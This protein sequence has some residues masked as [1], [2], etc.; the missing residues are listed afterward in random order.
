MG[1]LEPAFASWLPYP[2]S[3]CTIFP[4]KHFC[5]SRS[6]PVV[7]SVPVVRWP[8]ED[9]VSSSARGT[10]RMCSVLSTYDLPRIR[11]PRDVQESIF[12]RRLFPYL[13]ERVAAP[14]G[15]SG[16]RVLPAA[17]VFFLS[18]MDHPLFPR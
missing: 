14:F 7:T 3:P 5:R 11:H 8:S 9:R 15:G 13:V 16:G 2:S 4:L 1:M 6:V 12:W 17:A 18:P 10:P